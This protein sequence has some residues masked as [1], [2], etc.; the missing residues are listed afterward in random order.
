ME[1]CTG[2]EGTGGGAF[3]PDA[4]GAQHGGKLPAFPG[5]LLKEIMVNNESEKAPD[6]LLPFQCATLTIDKTL[7]KFVRSIQR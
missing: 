4:L 3:P 6:S 7:R 2:R 5:K 1:F